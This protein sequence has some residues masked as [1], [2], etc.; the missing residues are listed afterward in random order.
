MEGWGYGARP[1]VDIFRRA[2]P[3]CPGPT[4]AVRGRPRPSQ[5]TTAVI[6][7]RGSRSYRCGSAWKTASDSAV[8]SHCCDYSGCPF[9]R[10]PRSHDGSRSNPWSVCTGPGWSGRT[11]RSRFSWSRRSALVIRCLCP[12][13]STASSATH[14]RA[15]GGP[16]S[17]SHW[18]RSSAVE[19]TD[20]SRCRA[21][22]RSFSR[23]GP[24]SDHYCRFRE[25]S[26]RRSWNLSWTSTTRSL[27][28]STSFRLGPRT[29]ARPGLAPPSRL[30][31]EGGEGAGAGEV[32]E[33]PRERGR[34]RGVRP[35]GDRTRREGGVT[36]RGDGSS[37]QYGPGVGWCD[38]AS[39]RRSRGD[40]SNSLYV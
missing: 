2:R 12:R 10:P 32:V 25:V 35:S 20:R 6:D 23:T 9:H 18:C 15:P 34:L 39:G 40:P 8:E 21:C 16:G 33:G 17:R 31:E 30:G 5:G 14:A 22:G 4:C 29:P 37:Y 13:S 27:C 11:R 36:P 24:T 19:C 3:D 26:M 28:G 38:R 7:T 1:R